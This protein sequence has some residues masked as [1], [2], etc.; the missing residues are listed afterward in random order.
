MISKWD[1][2]LQRDFQERVNV[3]VVKWK[4]IAAY[5]HR[6][7]KELNMSVAD[8]VPH[9]SVQFVDTLDFALSSL[10]P[11]W[12][13]SGWWYHELGSEGPHPR[14]HSRLPL[15]SWPLPMSNP[16][17]RL[18][19]NP[20]VWSTHHS[21]EAPRMRSQSGGRSQPKTQ[22]RPSFQIKA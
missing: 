4:L 16:Q 8:W 9:N 13:S 6:K 22:T 18:Q 15:H 10:S 20:L 17:R 5:R 11:G 1:S 2:K 3:T 21:L 7:L 19:S 12:C 14:F